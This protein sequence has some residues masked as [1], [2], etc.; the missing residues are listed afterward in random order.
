MN[1]D[2][3]DRRNVAAV[4]YDLSGIALLYVEDEID[5]RNMVGKMLAMN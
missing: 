3:A 2:A 5:A 1:N 4:P